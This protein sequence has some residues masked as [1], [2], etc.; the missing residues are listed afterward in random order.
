MPPDQ[1]RPTQADTDEP[2][3]HAPAKPEPY[4]GRPCALH[5][6]ER[7]DNTRGNPHDV[8][9]ELLRHVLQAFDGRQ[10]R[11]RGRNQPIAI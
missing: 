1:D 8:G 3:H 2:Q 7:Q 9:L 11:D 6:E 10:N 5:C 4:P